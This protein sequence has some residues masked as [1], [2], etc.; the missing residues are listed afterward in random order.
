MS[1]FLQSVTPC[2]KKRRVSALPETLQYLLK[3]SEALGAVEGDA[4]QSATLFRTAD[5]LRLQA[6]LTLPTPPEAA[7]KVT[8][9]KLGTELLEIE[10]AAVERAKCIVTGACFVMPY[11]EDSVEA[12]NVVFKS[13]KKVQRLSKRGP[14]NAVSLWLNEL[15]EER[16]VF[17][18]PV[19][20]PLGYVDEKVKKLRE[21]GVKKE[22][23]DPRYLRPIYH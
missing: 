16:P 21:L 5:T 20:L 15:S 9:P 1:I 23:V 2:K 4:V 14:V 13:N 6:E 18:F 22:E 11:P 19:V 17:K 12:A 7:S 8:P 10:E 3:A